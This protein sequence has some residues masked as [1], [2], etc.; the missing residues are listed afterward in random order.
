MKIKV[1]LVIPNQEVQIVKIP[2][3]LKFIKSFIGKNLYRVK[4][5]ED[6]ILI[7]NNDAQIDEFNRILGKKIV[8]G[9]FLIVGIKNKHRVSLKKRQIRKFTNMFAL[10]KHQKKISRYKDQYLEEFYCRQREIKQKNAEEHSREFL[11]A[12]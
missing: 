7:A 4:L 6:T 9:T 11:N 1:L 3:N 12:A 5:N 8:L 10:K 2:A